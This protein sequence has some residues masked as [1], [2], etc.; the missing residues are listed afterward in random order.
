MDADY[1]YNANKIESIELV[2]VGRDP[3]PLEAQNIPFI[4]STWEQLNGKSAGRHL[5]NSLFSNKELSKFNTPRDAVFSLLDNG[6]VLLNASYNYL[7]K[8][9]ISLKKHRKYVENALVTNF[10]IL[11]KSTKVLMCGDANKMLDWVIELD[12]SFISV[13]HPAMQSLNRLHNKEKWYKYWE[14]ETLKKKYRK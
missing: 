3:F 4:K 9:K 1:L 13:P 2:I 5:F 14:V 12:K 7:E 11:E 6:I 8:E 10:P